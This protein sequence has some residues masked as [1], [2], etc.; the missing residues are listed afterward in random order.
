LSSKIFSTI[1]DFPSSTACALINT[2]IVSTDYLISDECTAKSIPLQ[3]KAYSELVKDSNDEGACDTAFTYLQRLDTMQIDR[4]G[5]D[6]F[7]Q[8]LKS[9]ANHGE[10]V[11]EYLQRIPAE[12]VRQVFGFCDCIHDAITL[13]SLAPSSVF[14][15]NNEVKEV[16]SELLV[17]YGREQLDSWSMPDLEFDDDSGKMC[18]SI[19]DIERAE[20]EL[21]G[22]FR[23]II[24]EVKCLQDLIDV[25][26]CVAEVDVKDFYTAD[27]D[28]DNRFSDNSDAYD[29][30]ARQ[31]DD[32]FA[33][34]ISDV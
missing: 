2:L 20:E 10:A 13:Y 6:S 3:L 11:S 27:C 30:G 9:V 4:H 31:I 7:I 21:A 25:W 34:L 12:S 8:I 24:S 29:H 32:M 5:V 15:D 26:D 14:V 17:E 22:D 19:Y 1:E 28:G 18:A 33:N 23:K 16:I